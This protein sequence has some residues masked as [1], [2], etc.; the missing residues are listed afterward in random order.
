MPTENSMIQ[1]SNF[2]LKSHGPLQSFWI[3]VNVDQL[4]QSCMKSSALRFEIL[5][6]SP[7]TLNYSEDS[8]PVG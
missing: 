4:G 6:L 8:D 2:E 5:I 1:S 3:Y 7:Y